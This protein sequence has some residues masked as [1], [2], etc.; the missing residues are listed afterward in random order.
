MDR[1]KNNPEIDIA[2]FLLNF[3]IEIVIGKPSMKGR[4]NEL[5]VGRREC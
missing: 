1:F 2:S 4:G 3:R 5:Y